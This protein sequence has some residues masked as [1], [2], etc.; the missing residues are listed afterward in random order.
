MT[1]LAPPPVATQGGA[2]P[3]AQRRRGRTAGRYALLVLAA[4]VVLAPLWLALTIALNPAPLVVDFRPRSLVVTDPQWHRFS[5]AFTKAELDRYLVNSAIVSLAITVGQVLTSILSAYAFAFLDFPMKRTLFAL[6]LA[7]LMIPTEII[8]V[9]NF[10]TIEGLG[11]TDTYQGL[12]VPFL[13][14]AFGTFLLRQ[15]FLAL[16]RDLREAAQLDGYG[17]WGFLWRVAVPLARPAIAALAT[18]SFLVAW[19][20]YL[21]P[22]LVTNDDDHRTVQVGLRQLI[23]PNPDAIGVTMAGTL[24]AALPMFLVLVVFQRHLV[25][26][27]TA[28]AVK[29]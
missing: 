2:A 12:A 7:T 24:L 4:A 14:F 6:F 19:N 29:G 9:A 17:H 26:G 23:D 22:L 16:P 27:L 28:G 3:P 11:W 10:D 1:T 8:A 18:F 20:Q 25:R 21:W 5:D 13:A 15:A